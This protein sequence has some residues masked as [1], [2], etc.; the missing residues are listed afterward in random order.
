MFSLLARIHHSSLEILL[1][2]RTPH[3]AAV[4]TVCLLHW[5]AVSSAHPE[6]GSPQV[7]GLGLLACLSPS[8][9]RVPLPTLTS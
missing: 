7:S 1:A 4:A 5:L 6:R 3:P 9:R 8:Y 2:S